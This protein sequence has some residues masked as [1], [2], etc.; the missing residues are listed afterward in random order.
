MKLK[1]TILL[2]ENDE[3]VLEATR[4]LLVSKGYT[5]FASNNKDD[6]LKKLENER[7]YLAVIDVRLRDDSDPEDVSGLDFADSLNPEIAKI[8]LTSYLTPDVSRRALTKYMEKIVPAE[9]A[10]SKQDGSKALIEAIERLF[11]KISGQV[12]LDSLKIEF[13]KEF[14]LQALMRPITEDFP[15]LAEDEVEE[16]IRR[17]FKEENMVKI[18]F[19]PPGRGGAGVALIRPYYEDM[20]GATVVMK[21]GL[22]PIIER[23]LERY[24]KY[25]EPFVQPHSTIILGQPVQTHRLAACKLLFVGSAKDHLLDFDAFYTNSSNSDEDLREVIHNIFFQ[26]CRIWYKGKRKW[27]KEDGL[28]SQALELQ[29]WADPSDFHRELQTTDFIRNKE[30]GHNFSG[31][32]R[33]STRML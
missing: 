26:T 32:G 21:F 13:N 6:A 29:L 25:V 2:L 23:E 20:E 22:S 4:D 7:I 9:D 1:K 17:L 24:K 28:L 8:I 14:S 30:N 15:L 27:R 16:L 31:F 10:V 5:V 3:D 12:N 18:Y 33:C 11:K 19:L